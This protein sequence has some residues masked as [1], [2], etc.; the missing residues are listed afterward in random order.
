MNTRWTHWNNRNTI[1][2]LNQPGI[3]FIALSSE[4]L[5]GKPFSL[6]N[7][8]IY[9]GMSISK[10]G[11]KGRLLQFEGAMKGANGRHGG[12]ERVRFKHKDSE[13]FFKNVYVSVRLFPVS[14]T[15]NTPNDWKQ[16]GE[17]VKHEY[18]SFGD[19][20]DKYGELPEFND[21]NR[22]KKK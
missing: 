11:V 2:D 17:C 18:V 10:K 3:Y 13:K 21:M 8:V 16:K 20:L 15:R 6:I 19:Y 5:E 22:S 14:S 12:A 9:I 1:K 4:N 7:E